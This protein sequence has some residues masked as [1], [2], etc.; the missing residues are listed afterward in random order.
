M[1]NTF[2]RCIGACFHRP[3]GETA[4]GKNN[5]V[6]VKGKRHFEKLEKKDVYLKEEAVTSVSDFVKLN[7]SILVY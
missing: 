7:L 3:A 2:S 5:K 6:P 4:R 1:G